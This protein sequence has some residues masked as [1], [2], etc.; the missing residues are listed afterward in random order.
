MKTLDLSKNRTYYLGRLPLVCTEIKRNRYKFRF[1]DPD[2]PED[3]FYFF[4]DAHQVET[5]LSKDGYGRTTDVQSLTKVNKSHVIA[6]F[7]ET[8]VVS[9]QT[10]YVF[11]YPNSPEELRVSDAGFKIKPTD[12]GVDIDFRTVDGMHHPLDYGTVFRFTSK[13]VVIIQRIGSMSSLSLYASQELDRPTI[14]Q[15]VSRLL[16]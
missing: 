1:G 6:T 7:R 5:L 12:D 8:V 16:R 14:W 2:Q 9:K 15:R 13:G 4:L 11:V 3:E 10:W